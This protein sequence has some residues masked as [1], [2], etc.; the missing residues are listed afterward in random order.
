MDPVCA[1]LNNMA[2]ADDTLR[3][4]YGVR[5]LAAL[6][7]LQDDRAQVC[8]TRCVHW[9]PDACQMCAHINKGGCHTQMD[10]RVGMRAVLAS[11]PACECHPLPK[12]NVPSI[13]LRT[14]PVNVGELYLYRRFKTRSQIS[15]CTARCWRCRSLTR[16]R[17][18]SGSG[19]YQPGRR[20][21]AW[22]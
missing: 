22:V 19:D 16:L 1:P 18:T 15:V 20:I 6:Q 21:S 11:P 13:P 8:N 9:V 2:L 7:Q 3:S 12:P 17:M 4:R 5:P 10:S 14:L